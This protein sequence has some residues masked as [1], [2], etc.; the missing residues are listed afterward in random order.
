MRRIATVFC[1]AALLF[2]AG[3]CAPS[4]EPDQTTNDYP[5][6][7]IELLAPAGSGSGYDLTI[8]SVAQCLL[9]TKLVSVPLPVT[10]MPGGGGIAALSYLDEKKGVNDV[11]SVYS[12]PLCLI[13]LNG[14]TELNYRDNTTPVA[15]LITAYGLFAV[16]KDSPYT[17]INE[18]MDALKEDPHAVIIG[19][20]S[21]P[22]SMDHIQFLKMAHKAG[23]ANLRDIEYV[24]FQDG[25]AAAQ[26][27]GGHVDLISTGISDSIGLVESGDIRALATTAAGRV[28]SGI[29]EEIPTCMEQG[30]DATFYNWR[31]IFGPKDMPEYAVRYWEDILGQMAQ[32][33]QWKNI[34]MKYGWEMTFSAQDDF[35][36][37]LDEVN[38]EYAALLEEIGY[39]D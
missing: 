3:S 13:N 32:T 9:D 20:I 35:V 10:N 28:G 21:A 7:S 11:L 19:G 37:F 33:E 22:G 38:E 26:L 29:V 18:V 25:T 6:K 23:V 15:K 2:I 16:N 30:I 17:T 1:A 39:L 24:G 5:K 4:I 8:R 27:M 14:S 34:C 12:P 36:G 31:G